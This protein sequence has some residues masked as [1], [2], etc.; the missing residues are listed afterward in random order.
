MVNFFLLTFLNKN[1][2][3]KNYSSG[4]PGFFNVLSVGTHRLLETSFE[5]KISSSLNFGPH[6]SLCDIMSSLG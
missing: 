4:I 2:N 5:L 3:K 1:S 6:T